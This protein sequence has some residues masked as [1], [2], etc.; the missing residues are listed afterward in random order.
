MGACAG[1]AHARR[2]RGWAIE[3]TGSYGKGSAAIWPGAGAGAEV[4][5]PR[6]AGRRAVSS[7]T[8]STPSSGPGGGR[9]RAVSRPGWAPGR[10][11]CG[12]AAHPRGR[13]RRRR[14]ASTSCARSIARPP[15]AGRAAARA[16]R[17]RLR[18]CPAPAPT[19]TRTPSLSGALSGRCLRATAE[20]EPGERGADQLERRSPRSTSRLAPQ[21]YSKGRRS[22][23]R[24]AAPHRLVTP[25]GSTPN[26][27]SPASPA[28]PPSPPAPERRSATGSTA[29][30]TAASTA[31]CTRSSLALRR[32]DPKPT[33]T[34]PAESPRARASERRSAASSATSP[35]HSSA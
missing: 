29:A 31:P 24:R 3:G 18:R 16:R 28:P 25:T 9:R 8:R 14:V 17:D 15:R 30:A 22:D 6:R 33:P 7:R 20:R 32:D 27:P 10:R 2:S 13:R 35:A 12:P 21:R 19:G 23:Q 26:P 34:S 11:R 1:P 5:R 4:E